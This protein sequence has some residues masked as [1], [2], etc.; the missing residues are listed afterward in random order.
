MYLCNGFNCF[1]QTLFCANSFAFNYSELFSSV[2]S[3]RLSLQDSERSIKY[4]SISVCGA[5]SVHGQCHRFTEQDVT[6]SI[7]SLNASKSDGIDV[8]LILIDV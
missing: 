3:S 4:D 1:V 2:F 8:C 6:S 5:E 7:K